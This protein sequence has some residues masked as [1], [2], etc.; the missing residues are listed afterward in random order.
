MNKLKL[1]DNEKTTINIVMLVS[2]ILSLLG[3]LV[4]TILYLVYKDL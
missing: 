2:N 4:I 1:S 3:S